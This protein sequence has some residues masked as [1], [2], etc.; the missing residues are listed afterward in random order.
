MWESS[1]GGKLN[2]RVYLHK[3]LLVLSHGV[4]GLSGGARRRLRAEQ[5]DAKGGVLDWREA[6]SGHDLGERLGAL[7]LLL[8]LPLPVRAVELESDR[9]RETKTESEGKR[10][11]RVGERQKA[12]INIAA[13]QASFAQAKRPRQSARVR[14]EH[15]NLSTL[16]SKY[17]PFQAAAQTPLHNEKQHLENQLSNHKLSRCYIMNCYYISIMVILFAR[18]MGTCLFF[19]HVQCCEATGGDDIA[20]YVFIVTVVVVKAF[21]SVGTLHMVGYHMV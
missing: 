5:L 10:Q 13:D 1:F 2:V 19:R 21:P 20:N 4:E 18:V 15:P 6:W 8:L 9:H 3:D 12:N 7:F 16:Q 14:V 17:C 11:S